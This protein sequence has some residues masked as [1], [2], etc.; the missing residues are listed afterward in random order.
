MWMHQ[1]RRR[2]GVGRCE[3]PGGRPARLAGLLSWPK[4]RYASARP[5]ARP[6]R[7]H[8]LQRVRAGRAFPRFVAR[9]A[10]CRQWSFRYGGDFAPSLAAAAAALTESAWCS[11]ACSSVLVLAL[12]PARPPARP[13]RPAP[14]RPLD[15]SLIAATPLHR[16]C[17]AEQAGRRRRPGRRPAPRPRLP[18]PAALPERAG[19]GALGEG[20]QRHRDG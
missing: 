2:R 7:R 15:S 19:L 20:V 17:P 3:P 14:P 10:K 5:P 18:L 13:P 16:R 8:A 9:C 1:R 4:R 11:G 6:P 12:S